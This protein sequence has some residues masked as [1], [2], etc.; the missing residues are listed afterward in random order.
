MTISR[1]EE[2]RA[3]LMSR[4]KYILDRQSEL[5]YAREEERENIARNALAK[6]IPIETIHEITGLDMETINSFHASRH[7]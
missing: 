5:S 1:D 3:W 2:E 4:E 6:G 7:V